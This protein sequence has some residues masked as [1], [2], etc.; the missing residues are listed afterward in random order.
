MVFKHKRRVKIFSVLVCVSGL[1]MFT[2]WRYLTP[3]PIVFK[4]CNLTALDP[5]DESLR[6]FLVRPKPLQCVDK[7]DLFFTRKDG[8]MYMNTSLAANRKLHL[9]G[10]GCWYQAVERLDGDKQLRMGPRKRLILPGDA[11][12]LIFCVT[13]EEVRS[14]I[15]R[16]T[17]F[18]NKTITKVY[19]M[20]HV[21]HFW[22]EYAKHARDIEVEK[23]D[24]PSVIMLG[25]D[26]VSRSH[27]IRNLK[28]SFNFLRHNLSC[29]DMIGHRK[30]GDNTFPNLIPLLTGKSH[31][32]FLDVEFLKRFAD[33]MPLLWNEKPMESIATFMAEDNATY[34]TFNSGKSG[35]NKIPT[36]YYFRPYSLA[37]EKF[38]PVFST[39]LG[40]LSENC[41]GDRNYFDIQ[42]EYL[43]GFLQKYNKKR[44]FAFF[45]SNVVTHD[46]FNTASLY[47]NSLLE[48]LTWMTSDIDINNTI[49]IVLS[50][51]GFRIGG[52]SLTHIGRAENSNP[53]LMVH[54][55]DHLTKRYPSIGRNLRENTKR[56]VTHYDT[57]NTVLEL[58]HNTAFLERPEI[59]TQEYMVKRN[60]FHYIPGD[61]TCADGGIPD[62]TCTCKDRVP[63]DIDSPVVKLAV[64]VLILHMNKVLSS[65]QSE[66]SI[67]RLQNITE[68][69]AI[70]SDK[71]YANVNKDLHLSLPR[72]I[73][74]MVGLSRD[75]DK[76]SGLYTVR[77]YTNPGNAYFEGTV[78][79]SAFKAGHQ[80]DK[81]TVVGEQSRLNR[82][83]EQS[84][85]V[86]EQLYKQICFC[87]DLL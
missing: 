12:T 6:P 29:Y 18:K 84:H 74:G 77:F 7:Y 61:R 87:K 31:W 1:C 36:D 38:E 27:A 4:P 59:P 51:H 45:W 42:L 15:F 81:V 16:V 63:V 64:D 76:D 56:L 86:S 48:F 35:F 62:N 25:I 41:Y 11:R 83:G 33:Y 80:A 34:S 67:I 13:P 2:K 9:Q 53:W 19:D 14:H 28:Q 46:S 57:Y 52:A 3:S 10:M 43:K 40:S 39:P 85:C 69:R 37:M 58:I 65:K 20:V 66:C 44:K 23:A 79:Y 55:P 71:D 82:Y 72:V 5:W 75:I 68:A 47:D 26:S 30:V 60:I 78:E 32:S 54:V 70:Y 50:D 8:R 21:N 73:G 49:L 24:T 22:N 17:C